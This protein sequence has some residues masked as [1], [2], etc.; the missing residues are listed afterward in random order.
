M[1]L[2][3][4]RNQNLIK[5]LTKANAWGNFMT[6]RKDLLE[7]TSHEMWRLLLPTLPFTQPPHSQPSVW[8]PLIARSWLNRQKGWG[9]QM[10]K[11][12]DLESGE[13]G[14]GKSEDE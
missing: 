12:A 2:Q 14:V 11:S 13:R 9:L 10:S 7:K 6:T 1:V 3:W 5:A 4:L 8:L